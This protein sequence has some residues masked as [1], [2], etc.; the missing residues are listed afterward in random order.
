M[1]KKIF[2]KA[3]LLALCACQQQ[4]IDETA[5]LPQIS[6]KGKITAA[7]CN[8][9]VI[10]LVNQGETMGFQY[11]ALSDLS[12]HLGLK[13]ESLTG[14]NNA[15]N[16]HRPAAK[17]GAISVYDDIFRKYGAEI[18]WDWRLLAALVY[19]E[20]RFIPNVRSR[21]G[22]YG[23]MQLM[24]AT[25]AHFG[26]DTT[27]TPDR[28]IAV[29][30]AYIKY[31]DRMFVQHVT[32]RDERIKFVLASYNIGPGHILDAR[33]LAEKYGKDADVWD[34]NVDSC[35]ISK[36]DPKYYNDPEVRHGKCYG[37][38]TLIH[39]TQIMEQYQHYKR[40]TM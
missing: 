8:N 28:Q 21:K 5:N 38:E 30:A 24:P 25:L 6:E 11:E 18:G 35:L 36:S 12:K 20:S 1:I 10:G 22:A 34:N 17:Q 14:K 7:T 15:K 3:I 29:G 2:F 33:R 32:D 40:L 37:K 31:L 16:L 39:V 13:I 27:A 4:S 23:L 26:V 19:Q 9:T